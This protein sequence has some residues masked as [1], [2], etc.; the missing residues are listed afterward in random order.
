M[1]M[2]AIIKRKKSKTFEIRSDSEST[3]GEETAIKRQYDSP[4][5]RYT[6]CIC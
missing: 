2:V 1:H 4:F 5:H 6:N 3:S